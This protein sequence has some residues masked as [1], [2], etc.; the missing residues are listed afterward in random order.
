M[1]IEIELGSAELLVPV[2]RLVMSIA[3]NPGCRLRAKSRISS[4]SRTAPSRLASFELGEKGAHIGGRTH[5]LVGRGEVCPTAEAEDRRDLL[6]RGKKVK[7]ESVIRGIGAR[8]VGEKHALAQRGIGGK[9]H[10]RLHVRRIGGERHASLGVGRMA[11]EII[12]GQAFQF[13]GVR[14]MVFAPSWILRL[15]SSEMPRGFFM[16]RLQAI[17]RGLVLVDAG[18]PIAEQRALDVVLGRRIGAGQIDRRPD[19]S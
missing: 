3:F 2:T 4:C 16:Q 13:D 7:K 19:A 1:R 17:A 18:Q 9:G 15:K 6:P 8:V 10:D 14:S 5:H 12:G 11:S